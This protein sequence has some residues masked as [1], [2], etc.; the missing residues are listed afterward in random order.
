[1]D[2]MADFPVT[3]VVAHLIPASSAP[4]PHDI[5][6]RVRGEVEKHLRHIV[7][8]RCKGDSHTP[9]CVIPAWWRRPAQ[10]APRWW[11]RVRPRPGEDVGV[12]NPLEIEISAI[13]DIPRPS[14]LIEA[15]R[16]AAASG[17]ASRPLTVSRLLVHGDGGVADLDSTGVVWPS[18]A[19]LSALS[20][21]VGGGGATIVL[22]SP[23]QG[24]RDAERKP[25][26]ADWITSAIGR[27]R[28]LARAAETRVD[29]RW[30]DADPR[31]G[32]ASLWLVPGTRKA[33]SQAGN[34]DL[35]GWV[36]TFRLAAEEVA[37]YADL[38]AAAEVL[39]V[40]RGVTRGLGTIDVQWDS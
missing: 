7:C 36:G 14:A 30:P 22:T 15:I 32:A 24:R 25:T 29:V 28:A 16:R 13:A 9:H 6:S 34:Q 4:L 40:G 26:V 18:A 31:M 37:P 21:P 12:G 2:W 19:P 38:V 35:S 5:G 27:V 23:Y 3:R 20:R 11:L 8:A 33:R 39:S 1:M 10:E 17:I